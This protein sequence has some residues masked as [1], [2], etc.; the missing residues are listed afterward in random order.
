MV[1]KQEN[2]KTLGR[3]LSSLLGQ[4][5]RDFKEKFNDDVNTSSALRA[6]NINDLEPGN[7]QPRKIFSS[8]KLKELAISIRK[9]GLLQPII[10]REKISSNGKFQIIAG[11]RRWRACKSLGFNKID[12]IIKNL[13]DRES[14]ELALIENIQRSDLTLL[15]EAEGYQK[16]I[17]EFNYTQEELSEKIGKSRSHIANMLRLLG[18]PFALKEMLNDG[19]ISMGH[20]R[21][22]LSL[23]DPI[24]IAKRVIKDKLN[25]RQT[26]DLVRNV[27]NPDGRLKINNK[28]EKNVTE[29]VTVKN[30]STE[31]K[32]EK[33]P[34]IIELE[35][36]LTNNIGLPVFIEDVDNTGSVVIKFNSLKEL[37]SIIQLL[38]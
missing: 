8:E 28:I 25:V 6:L 16:L 34:D 19:L 29:T 10:V 4:S 23:E 22:L 17:D 24:S 20:A 36:T 13:D 14:L 21:A 7:F 2:T 11:E 3:G 12:A 15:E 27:L 5:K 33:D 1:N 37:D 38:S 30:I 9:N 26:E 18:L 32:K 31:I 35:N